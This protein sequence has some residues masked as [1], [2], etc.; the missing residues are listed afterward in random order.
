MKNHLRVILEKILRRLPFARAAYFKLD[1]LQAKVDAFERDLSKSSVTV[2][3]H[4]LK[5]GFEG[6][7]AAAQVAPYQPDSLEDLVPISRSLEERTMIAERCRDADGIVKV[8]NAGAVVEGPEGVRIQIMHN[9]VKVIAGGYY[10]A[11]MQDLIMRCRGHHEPQE[12]VL[13]TEIMK[14][15]G[16]DAVMFELGGFWSFY[17]IWFLK[18]HPRRRGFIVEADPAN[19]KV[20]VINAGLND[21]EPVFISAFV[22]QHAAAPADFTTESSGVIQLPCVSVPEMMTK[23][24]ID[25]LD[26][27]HCDAQG[28]ELAVLQSCEEL[29]AAG[30]LNW[31]V[32]STH[33]HYISGD[34]LTHQRCLS[35]LRRAGAHILAEHDVHES[36]SGDGMIV[37]KFG[38]V[39]ESWRTPKLSYNRYSESLFRNPLYDLAAASRRP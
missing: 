14:H 36:F 15:L 12:E 17:S 19:L 23:Y 37:A 4:G 24:D 30:R 21:C 3:P 9:G 31:L 27:L 6:L 16:P 29:A 10:G 13:F 18:G 8:A 39:P 22:G 2:V 5:L 32:I 1:I 25:R 33:T 35:V 11:W 34:P 7:S 26:L 28:V 20:G 38:D